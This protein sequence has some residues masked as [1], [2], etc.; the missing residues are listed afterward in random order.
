MTFAPGV[1]HCSLIITFG[2]QIILCGHEAS[3]SE[4]ADV[5]EAQEFCAFLFSSW[6][7]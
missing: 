3:V 2:L 4:E 6:D 5:S 1:S 7:F